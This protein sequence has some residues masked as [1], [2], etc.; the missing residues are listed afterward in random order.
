MITDVAM[1]SAASY[2]IDRSRC[3]T[4]SSDI[5]VG[6]QGNATDQEPS[7]EHATRLDRHHL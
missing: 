5:D 4:M 3:Q 6:L 1:G 2:V 7:Y